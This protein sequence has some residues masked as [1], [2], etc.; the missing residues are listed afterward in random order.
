MPLPQTLS[1]SRFGQSVS[2]TAPTPQVG[3]AFEAMARRP[4][5]KIPPKRVHL[6]YVGITNQTLERYRQ[7]I[8]RF[9]IFLHEFMHPL[10]TSLADLDNLAGEYINHLYQDDY[11]VHFANDLI[12]GLKRLYPKC[13]KSLET[14]SAWARNWTK[15]LSR[16]RATPISR[17]LVMGMAT[18]AFRNSVCSR[19]QFYVA[20]GMENS[21]SSPND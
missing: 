5:K 10:P 16:T 13:R 14:A 9:F 8:W 17:E 3:V 21:S 20:N 7:A 18:V 4:R 11:G 1:C 15:S 2:G 6:K 19:F 12:S